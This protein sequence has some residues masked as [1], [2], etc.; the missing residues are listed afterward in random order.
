MR[1]RGSK[2]SIHYS[3]R[4][5]LM[6]VAAVVLPLTFITVGSGVASATTLT[7]PVSCTV[8]S[9]KITFTG[10]LF[11]TTGGA[12]DAV[13]GKLKDC[14]TTEAG[15]TH[16]SGSVSATVSGTNT[17]IDGLAGGSMKVNTFTINWKGKLNGVAFTATSKDAEHGDI[18]ATCASGVGFTLPYAGTSTVTGAFAGTSATLST[19]CSTTSESHPF[20][21]GRV[22][23]RGEVAEAHQRDDPHRLA[24]ICLSRRCDCD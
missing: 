24:Q 10:G 21:E 4:K 11:V 14:T 3:S 7:G 9:I 2:M 8:P 18:G 23:T 5:I 12:S 13:A 22:T 17:G 20:D 19:L 1:R 16:L 15:I 6:G